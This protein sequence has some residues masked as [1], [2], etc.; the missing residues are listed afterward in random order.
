MLASRETL[1]VVVF[2]AVVTALFFMPA[3]TATAHAAWD[4]ASAVIKPR[5]ADNG[6][7]TGPCG[8]IARTATPAQFTPGQVI[9]VSW[10]ETVNHPGSYRIAFSPAND[11]G[12]DNTVLYTA[13]DTLG[14]ETPVPHFYKTT[15][16]LP[17]QSC[18][19]CTLQLIQVMTESTPPSLYY[20]CADIRIAAAATGGGTTPAPTPTIP[21]DMVV[22]AQELLDDFSVADTNSNGALSITEIQMLFPAFTP[23]QFDTI[24]VANDGMLTQADLESFITPPPATPAGG[25]SPPKNHNTSTPKEA[26]STAAAS[27]DWL[28]LA[29]MMFKLLGDCRRS[30]P[31]G[32]RI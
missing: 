29:A 26:T 12:F 2:G 31:D 8:G 5:S 16:A 21:S 23:L 32:M 24:D 18:E 3:R 25:S 27:L 13:V 6:L 11:S 9:E 22:F 1:G 14:T 4:P 7:K 30:V 10:K 20:S 28:L 15:I 17:T 19:A